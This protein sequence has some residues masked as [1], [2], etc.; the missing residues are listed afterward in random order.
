MKTVFRPQFWIDLEAGVAY[1]A[2]NASSEIA[3]SWHQEVMAT[4]RRVEALPDVG[5]LRNDL[6]PSGIRS[7]V[8]RRYQ[9]YVLFYF[10]GKR[11]SKSCASNMA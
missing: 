7:L 2:K 5:R 6:K 11:R 9:R 3:L 10:G 8:L 4:V 1:L